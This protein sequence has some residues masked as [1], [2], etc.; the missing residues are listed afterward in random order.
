MIQKDD[1]YQIKT[2][3]ELRDHY[4]EAMDIVVR[5]KL[6]ALDDYAMDFIAKAPIVCIGSEMAEGV[7]VSPRGGAPGFVHVLD[8]GHVAVPDWPGNNK[9][10]TM[11]N[12]LSTGRCGLLFLV[13]GNDLF[14]RIN[15]DAIITRDPD[16]LARMTE[17]DKTPKAAI[18]IAIKEC[19]FHCGKAIKRSKI[20]D[21]TTWPDPKGQP[22]VG[23]MMVDQAR[24][25]DMTAEEIQ[26]AYEENLR[27]NLY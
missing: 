26:E 19:Y 1:P 11:T 27:D 2:V 9:L 10:E 13:P 17:R 4:D 22:N 12:I 3:E 21:A 14:L 24:I 18:R 6:K 5:A 25:T 20:W 23:R 8:R 15:G 7:D 16:L